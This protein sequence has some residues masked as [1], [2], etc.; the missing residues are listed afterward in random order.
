MSYESLAARFHPL[1]EEIGR[2]AL[3]RE[4]RRELPHEAVRSL[5]DA[6][7]TSLTVPEAFG[8]EG[9][10]HATI[11]RLLIDL[12]AADS[13]VAHLL[14]GHFVFIDIAQRQDEAFARRHLGSMT[15][16]VLFGNASTDTP[17]SN[18]IGTTSTTLRES[19]DGLL[20]S[21]TKYYTTGTIFAD[22]A[23]VMA[24][25]P[26]T[27][28]ERFYV[29]TPT[30]APGVRIIDDWDGFGQP[31]TGTGT[32]ILDDVRIDPADVVPRSEGLHHDSAYFQVILLAVIAGIGRAAVADI[33]GVVRER[34]RTFNTAGGALPR[35]DPIIQENL[36]RLHAKA[37]AAEA[38]VRHAAEALDAD[39]SEEG[40]FEAAE[41]A[42]DAAQL[43]VPGLVADVTT[44]IF[45]LSGASATKRGAALDRY[46]RNARTIATH[47]PAAFKARAI[48]DYLLSGTRPEGL[49]SI[50]TVATSEGSP[51]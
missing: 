20:L 21:G 1:F 40:A 38:S 5:V 13:N 19:E 6:G 28:T 7:F 37:V 45:D 22:R 12:A 10:S 16:G 8:G 11:V 34:T 26:D 17:G 3:A 49:N 14:R 42:A 18:T 31:L 50:G 36:G 33:T 47:N 25:A 39:P 48:G 51:A 29:V 4:Q 30:D 41:L 44:G 35:E 2:G 24:S 27:P 43:V 46:W 9:V 32:T 15:R 23:V